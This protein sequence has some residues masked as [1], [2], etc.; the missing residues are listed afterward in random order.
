M[1]GAE[2]A[3]ERFCEA[4]ALNG[5]GTITPEMLDFVGFSAKSLSGQDLTDIT[6]N[7]SGS[8]VELPAG[9]LGVAVGYEFREQNGFFDPDP[10]VAAGDSNGVPAFASSGGY[11]VNEIYGE[12]RV[13]LLR[14]VPGADLLEVSAA[15]RSTDYDF[16]SSETTWRGSFLWRP[17]NQLS[18]RGSV[19]TGLRAPS[20][21]ELFT[22]EEAIDEVFDDPCA[23]DRLS[24]DPDVQAGCTV[25]G[26]LN[27]FQ[28]NEQLRIIALGNENL[29]P[30][31][32]DNVTLGLTYAPSW[33]EGASCAHHAKRPRLPLVDGVRRRHPVD[34]AT[35]LRDR[36]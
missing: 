28:P 35:S 21:G 15:V 22:T 7:I 13:P 12:I 36:V 25:F 33:G 30:E 29:R 17:V 31:E 34:G 2:T 32:S 10:I 9:P 3:E 20:I 23:E 24:P 6:F 16:A 8:L 4:G 26:A 18:F 14:D 5:G 1:P 11:D 27:T 19:S